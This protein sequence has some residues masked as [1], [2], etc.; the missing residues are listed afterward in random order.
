MST[1]KRSPSRIL[2][3]EQQLQGVK[4]SSS[5]DINILRN[6]DQAS[7]MGLDSQFENW[8]NANGVRIKNNSDDSVSDTENT[9]N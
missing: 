1:I 4:G 7:Q 8:Q 3:L 5:N 2:Y 6:K 9:A